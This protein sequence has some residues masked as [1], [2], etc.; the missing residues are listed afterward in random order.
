M[1]LFRVL[2]LKMEASSAFDSTYLITKVPVHK[3]SEQ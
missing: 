2:V 3:S 1:F